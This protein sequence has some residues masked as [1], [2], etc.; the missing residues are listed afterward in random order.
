MRI[1]LL[2]IFAVLLGCGNALAADPAI[3]FQTHP[4]SRIL[5]EL[6][7]TAELIGG[8]KGVKV[9]NK[10]IKDALGEKGFEGLDLGR[11]IVGYVLLAPKPE[12]ITAVVAFPITGEKEFLDLCERAN[13]Q[14]PKLAGKEKDVYELPPLDPRYKALMRFSDQYAYIS[15]GAKPAPALDP[16]AL[17]PAQQIYIPT[18]KGLIAGRIYFDRI[19]VAVKLA[20]P[21]L[22]AE[23]KKTILGGLYL[24]RDEQP[25]VKAIVPEVE[26][27]VGRYLKLAAGADEMAARINIDVETGKLTTELTLNG[28]K[29]SELSTIIAA[30]KPTENKFGALIATPDTIAGFKF[31]LPLF[32]EEI[33]T[34]AVAG[35]EAG[36]KEATRNIPDP[37]K[38]ALEE[39]FKGLGRTVKTGEFDIVAGVRGPDKNG[40]YTAVGAIAFEDPAALEKEFKKLIQNLALQNIQDAIKW[41]AAKAGKVSIHTWKMPAGGF[42]DITKIFG[43]DDCTIAFA[44]APHGVFA[45]IGPDAVGTMK[46]ALAVKPVDSPVLDV[47]VNPARV[48]KLLDKVSGP[49]GPGYARL[50]AILGKED[51]LVSVMSATLEG[52]KELKMAYSINLRL[53]LRAAILDDLERGD[54]LQI[55]LKEGDIVELKLKERKKPGR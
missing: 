25:I 44:F 1:G 54:R 5:G 27:L 15:Y 7:A 13:H 35:L 8:E 46:D 12:D 26:K 37:I 2:A 14:K 41:D 32:E 29:G 42:L 16:K 53:I 48:V 30:R 34:A 11:P 36:Q 10:R 45:V 6:R 21:T 18:E 52:G 24:D 17:V 43:G 49:N 20:L 9:L 39:F 23:V 4:V 40:S 22:M 47:V 55:E 19:P 31:R 3:V 33:R 28:K 50:E 38:T 51:K